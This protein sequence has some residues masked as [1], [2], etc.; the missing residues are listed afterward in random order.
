[1]STG[2]GD[3]VVTADDL[4]GL[5][6]ALADPTRRAVMLRVADGGPVSA[7][8]LAR[9]LPVT[10]QAIARH[11]ELLRSAGLVASE[12]YGRETRFALTPARL[13]DL[14]AW[15]ADVGARWDSRL[16]LLRALAEGDPGGSGPGRQ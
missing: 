9:H 5:F 14:A 15:T 6:S 16:D 2:S 7:S 3:R 10:R 1:M 8:E 11:L 12:R 13:D 4:D